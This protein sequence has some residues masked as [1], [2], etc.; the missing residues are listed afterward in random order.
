M[1]RQTD[2]ILISGVIDD[3]TRRLTA[4]FHPLKIILFGSHARG[5]ATPDSDLDFLIVM[6]DGTDRR[7]AAIEMHQLLSD[8]ALPKDILVTTPSEI[9]QRGDLLGT[10]LRP[11]L[12]EGRVLYERH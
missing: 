4:Q 8:L 7:R 10:A 9:A 11:A 5:D 3:A 1:V 2:S 6:P 12:H